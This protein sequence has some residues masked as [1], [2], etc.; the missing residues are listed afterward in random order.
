MSLGPLGSAET[1]KPC[2]QLFRRGMGS[3]C[4]VESIER[5]KCIGEATGR[6]KFEGLR[7]PMMQR[8]EFSFGVGGRIPFRRLPLRYGTKEEV[9]DGDA[10]E[11]YISAFRSAIN[12]ENIL[13][14]ADA[15]KKMITGLAKRPALPET[16]RLTGAKI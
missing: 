12:A 10:G 9:V 16:V 5:H 6:V 3:C 13:G 11:K 7:E 1:F 4:L 14:N 15:C 8:R 2:N